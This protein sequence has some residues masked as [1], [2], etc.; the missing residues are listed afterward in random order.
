MNPTKFYRSDYL[1]SYVIKWI[2]TILTPVIIL[3]CNEKAINISTPS[4]Q[5]GDGALEQSA[6]DGFI[7]LP[8]SQVLFRSIHTHDSLFIDIA[9]ND[10]ITRNSILTNGLSV[11]I[12]PK[13][14]RNQTYG[15][16]FIAARSEM[17]KR[18]GEFIKLLAQE[19]A[20]TTAIL[21]L[22]AHT[23]VEAVNRRESVLKDNKGTR[24]ADENQ[25]QVYLDNLNNLHYR[26]HFGLDQIGL[27]PGSDHK[28][29]IGV[30]SNVHEAQM[31]SSQHGGSNRHP[32][33]SP[34]SWAQPPQTRTV[35]MP[36][37]PVNSWIIVT[38]PKFTDDKPQ[39]ESEIQIP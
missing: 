3:S 27:T 22:A 15:M 4:Y 37:V 13:A 8:E 38:L 5:R 25:T 33:G 28:I 10:N 19:N 32:M 23:W 20:D 26:M 21:M 35:A 16:T 2:L 6:N 39:P 17:L 11:W 7:T 34:R 24:F 9:I 1:H 30:I 36:Q 18:R 12:D 14:E 29:S 31:Q